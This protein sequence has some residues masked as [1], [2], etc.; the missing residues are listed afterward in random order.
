MK[1]N[2]FSILTVMI[3]AVAS[4]PVASLADNSLA[5]SPIG[6]IRWNDGD[7]NGTLGYSFTVNSDF[8][9]KQLGFFDSGALGLTNS[10]AVGLWDVNGTLLASVTIGAGLT[11]PIADGFR[12]ANLSTTALLTAGN[13]Y[14][15][16]GTLIANDADLMGISATINTPF[17]LGQTSLYHDNVGTD[18]TLRLPDVSFAQVSGFYGPNLAGSPVPIPSAGWLLGSGLVGLIGL[19]RRPSAR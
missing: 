3:L 8:L 10:H 17:T 5:S 1:K 19:R 15:L 2:L 13:T 18:T 14:T 16:G 9:T 11:A 12:W 7:V 4:L 6:D